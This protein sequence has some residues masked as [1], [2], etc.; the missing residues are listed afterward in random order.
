MVFVDDLM[1]GL[2]ALQEADE[3]LL[4][5]PQQGYCIPGLS[6][7]A[8]ELFAEIRKHQPGFGFRVELDENMAKF[9]RLWPD[10]LATEEPLRDLGYKPEVG[11]ADMV[12]SVLDAHEHRNERAAK[13]FQDIDHD[14]DGVVTRADIET[15]IRKF[16]VSGRENFEHAAQEDVDATV[17][18]F[19]A[20]MKD[21]D[22]RISWERFSEWNR[23]N[24]FGDFV[25]K[26]LKHASRATKREEKKSFFASG[27]DT[28]PFDF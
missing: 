7:S 18:S 2:I 3:D 21:T 1:R 17:D 15:H 26:A 12:S 24:T 25:R 13:D 8:N 23:N 28:L 22:G 20:E 11:L 27:K 10:E 9:A 19:M 6:F 4:G 5:E 16:L 14:G